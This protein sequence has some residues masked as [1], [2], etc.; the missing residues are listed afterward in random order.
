MNRAALAVAA[1][2][3]A[4]LPASGGATTTPTPPASVFDLPVKDLMGSSSKSL[5]L[6]STYATGS[7]DVGDLDGDGSAE[8][9][10]VEQSQTAGAVGPAT[11]RLTFGILNPAEPLDPISFR[12]STTG[13][14]LA[15]LSPVTIV[16]PGVT[17]G[18]GNDCFV[19][20]RSALATNR[21]S[22]VCDPDS[23]HGWDQVTQGPTAARRA[24]AAA[25]LQMLVP[26]DITDMDR[27]G[28]SE[29]VV[30]RYS[31]A[32]QPDGVVAWDLHIELIDAGTSET[33]ATWHTASIGLA[34]AATI[35]P[36]NRLLSPVLSVASA[37]PSGTSFAVHVSHYYM[38][39]PLQVQ[40]PIDVWTTTL[41]RPANPVA[42]GLWPLHGTEWEDGGVA[43]AVVSEERPSSG[44]RAALRGPTAIVGLGRGGIERFR[45]TLHS[46]AS[47]D[48]LY[49]DAGAHIDLRT[50]RVDLDTLVV[51]TWSG[52]GTNAKMGEHRMT[53]LEGDDYGKI[54][55]VDPI[56]DLDADG[57]TDLAIA[58]G[59]PCGPRMQLVSKT[60][61]LWQ[62]FELR[63]LF[64]DTGVTVGGTLDATPGTD[65]LRWNTMWSC[66]FL[67]ARPVASRFRAV[68]GTTGDILWETRLYEWTRIRH[69]QGHVIGDV[70][71]D[72]MDDPVVVATRF[73]LS[74]ARFDGATGALLWTAEL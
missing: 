57:V 14:G 17:I 27:D 54:V 71:G 48:L 64:C 23:P 39:S 67:G 29:I 37:V 30:G 3:F 69:A 31:G 21:L 16:R 36:I 20:T 32:E 35:A 26:L 10:M 18:G 22:L 44:L 65:V 66:C 53:F 49:V 61:M 4:T 19:L 11:D 25:G 70:D 40:Y 2:L 59:Y 72:G 8:V 43:V 42:I 6:D 15:G 28:T 52:A 38:A 13:P 46:A 58:G 34:P 1:I 63:S 45:V 68:N 74:A 24:D 73:P 62:I 7:L 47:V 55:R 60:T 41:P 56:G 33:R 5:V 9:V 12:A 51:E 50:V